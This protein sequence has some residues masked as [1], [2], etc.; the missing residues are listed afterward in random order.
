MQAL[1]SVRHIPGSCHII[2]LFYA[3]VAARRAQIS[4]LLGQS[5]CLT[6]LSADAIQP[7]ISER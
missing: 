5:S 1:A 7:R 4:L 2:E 3:W 6:P